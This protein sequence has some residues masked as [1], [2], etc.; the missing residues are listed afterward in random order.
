MTGTS[1]GSDSKKKKQEEEPKSGTKLLGLRRQTTTIKDAFVTV[2]IEDI[3]VE[4]TKGKLFGE[5]VF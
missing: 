5:N 1:T 2:K 3:V 4:F